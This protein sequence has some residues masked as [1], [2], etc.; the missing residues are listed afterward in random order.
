MF[1]TGFL[2]SFCSILYP[3]NGIL[4]SDNDRL[5]EGNLREAQSDGLCLQESS[6]LQTGLVS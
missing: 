2:F 6:G 1:A 5:V 4:L 3:L